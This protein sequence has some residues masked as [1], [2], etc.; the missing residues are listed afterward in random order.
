MFIE[1]ATANTDM[2]ARTPSGKVMLPP[3]TERQAEIL[4]YMVDVAEARRT[5]PS[6][7]EVA[8]RFSISQSAVYNVLGALSRKGYL[9]RQGRGV[10]NLMLTEVGTEWYALQTEDETAKQLSLPMAGGQNKELPTKS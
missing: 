4:R 3:L 9:A 7:R 2:V 5:W 6:Q 1:P 8:G 10:G